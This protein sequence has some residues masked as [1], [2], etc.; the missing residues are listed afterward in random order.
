MKLQ[1]AERQDVLDAMERRGR[2]SPYGSSVMERL[3]TRIEVRGDDECWPCGAAHTQMGH[4]SFH[5]VGY[6][7]VYAHQLTYILEYGPI[8]E[9]MIVRHTCDNPPCCNP[10]HLVL[11]SLSDNQRDAVERGR[12]ARAGGKPKLTPDLVRALR[13]RHADGERIDHM[14]RE[15]GLDRRTVGKAIDGSH[16]SKVT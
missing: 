11:G 12:H 13:Q 6:G 8:P 9:G 2:K 3:V 10:K 16:W 15:L 14:A 5:M 1:G 7:T 4:A